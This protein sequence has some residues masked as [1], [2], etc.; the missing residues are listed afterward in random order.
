MIFSDHFETAPFQLS[1]I[2]SEGLNMAQMTGLNYKIQEM[3]RRS[4]ELN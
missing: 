2:G 1:V 3:G 4:L